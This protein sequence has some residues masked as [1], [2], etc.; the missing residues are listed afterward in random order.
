MYTYVYMC[1]IV[2]IIPFAV[3]F[4]F[5]KGNEDKGLKQIPFSKLIISIGVI[6]LT[7]IDVISC[8]S[9]ANP[10]GAAVLMASTYEAIACYLEIKKNNSK[11]EILT[12]VKKVIKGVACI[13]GAVAILCLISIITFVFVPKIIGNVTGVSFF[14]TESGN[15]W[16]GFWGNYLGAIIGGVLSGSVAIYV[17]KRTIR[18]SKKEQERK[19]V[20]DF[21]DWLIKRDAEFLEK[22]RK[23]TYNGSVYGIDVQTEKSSREKYI[24]FVEICSVAKIA[25]FE[26]YLQ[27][28]V[29]R[30]Q[31]LYKNDK[32]EII[33][34]KAMM[35]IE[36]I[37][38]YT[39]QLPKIK[40][41][42]EDVT[43]HKQTNILNLA[44]ECDI[45]IQQYAQALYKI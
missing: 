9:K 16:I 3:L 22:I 21:A 33:H 26:I 45:E 44:N 42:G 41:I 1:F 7:L 38:D 12:V 19:E 29:K 30:E 13:I 17:M 4:I 27:L 11:E 37:E 40:E 20:R 10:L 39:Q 5:N 18:N 24:E 32:I 25:I 14:E 43:K 15:P 35:L 2:V 6:I 31:E 23:A 36:A 8:P 34:K 28:N